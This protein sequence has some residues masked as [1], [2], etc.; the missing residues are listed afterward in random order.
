M[1]RYT[2]PGTGEAPW[3]PEDRSDAEE[4]AGRP[5]QPSLVRRERSALVGPSVARKADGLRRGGLRGK[6]VIAILNTW[7][8][9]NPCHAHFRVRAEEVKRGVWQA[10]GFP[11][12][13]PVLSLGETFMKPTPMLYRNLLAMEAEELVRANPI[14]GAVL[15]GG[16]DKTVPGLLMGA[17]SANLPAIFL[18]AGP[19]L[20]GYWRGRRSAS[21]SDVW[22]YWAEKRAGTIDDC[23][24]RGDRGRHR[25]LVR[26]LHDDGHGVHDGGGGR[27]ARHDAA[28]RRR[29]SRGGLPPP[30]SRRR[31]RPAHRRDGVGGPEAVRVDVHGGVRECHHRSRG[32][33]RIH[34]RD[35]PSRRDGA[36]RGGIARSRSLRRAVPPDAA[37]GQ[38]PALRRVPDGGLLSTRAACPRCWSAC[39]ICSRSMR[40]R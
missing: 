38:Y 6:P 5:A 23:A 21:G 12:E 17:A 24:W 10:G 20:R 18:P 13:I 25:P 8:D 1:S 3:A 28:G 7:S 27:S 39:A 14:D 9:A 2:P 32:G 11:L 35:H 30:S 26:H 15:L 19:M 40:S 4:K 33:R 36:P 16:C 31:D 37:A 34:E 22:K 29:H